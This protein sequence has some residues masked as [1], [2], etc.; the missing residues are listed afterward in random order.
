MRKLRIVRTFRWFESSNFVQC[1]P[2][3]TVAIRAYSEPVVVGADY[4]IYAFFSFSGQSQQAAQ[5]CFV[6]VR[7]SSTIPSKKFSIFCKED[8]VNSIYGLC[9]FIFAAQSENMVDKRETWGSRVSF[10]LACIGY[11]VGLGNIWR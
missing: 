6:K 9:L 2:A 5:F 3:P 1:A 7:Y 10:L 11:A 4:I 8:Y